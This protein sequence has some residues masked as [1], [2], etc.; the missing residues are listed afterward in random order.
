MCL[1]QDSVGEGGGRR[2]NV[3]AEGGGGAEGDE[4]VPPPGR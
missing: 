2:W 3:R 1:Q 4:G